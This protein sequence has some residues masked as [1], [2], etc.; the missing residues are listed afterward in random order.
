MINIDKTENITAY[1]MANK[2]CQ[3]NFGSHKYNYIKE[4]ITNLNI[5][6]ENN[7]EFT[8]EK[9]LGLYHILQESANL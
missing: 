8:S 2:I 1:E 4:V 6:V 7:C 9:I 5:I 3:E